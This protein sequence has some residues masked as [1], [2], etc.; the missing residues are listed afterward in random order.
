[1]PGK[2]W[3][4]SACGPQVGRGKLLLW[5]TTRTQVNL[6]WVLLGAWQAVVS[7]KVVQAQLCSVTL[8][9]S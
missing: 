4:H 3:L 6:C 2:R 7:V 9:S 5:N 8:Y 1:M